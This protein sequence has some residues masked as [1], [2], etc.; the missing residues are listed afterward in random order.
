MNRPGRRVAWEPA[1]ACRVRAWLAAALAAASVSGPG[2]VAG[3]EWLL[4]PAMSSRL[5]YTDNYG[6]TPVNPQATW[7]GSAGVD[8]AVSRNTETLR[9]RA[10]TSLYYSYY[11]NRVLQPAQ[12]GYPSVFFNGEYRQPRATYG[13][14]LRFQRE[15]AVTSE[16]ATTGVALPQS[17]VRDTWTVAPSWSYSAT[18][19]LGFSASYLLTDASFQD[20]PQQGLFD[21]TN[22][23]LSAGA[24]YRL[25]EY[26]TVSVTATASR[27]ETNPETRESDT[28]SAQLAWSRAV[29]ETLLASVSYG[30]SDTRTTIFQNVVF[31]P[32][33]LILCQLG[34]VPLETARASAE[35]RSRSPIWSASLSKQLSAATSL[36]AQLRSDRYASATGFLTKSETASIALSH[37]MSARLNASIGASYVDADTGGTS[38]AQGIPVLSPQGTRY[39]AV[40]PGLTWQVLPELSLTAGARHARLENRANSSTATANTAFVGLRYA[41]PRSRIRW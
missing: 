36:L 17:A 34:F 23:A 7:V 24:S 15:P 30:V 29:S 11:S 26:D 38:V 4:E 28:T 31:C 10:G 2:R 32:A 1:T 16:L 8:L 33:P 37:A 3:A 22:Q 12:Q 19:R 20:S 35:V 39:L 27:Y 9:L 25:T 18:A 40:E 5:E 13:L 21:Y 6:L 41:W 14:A